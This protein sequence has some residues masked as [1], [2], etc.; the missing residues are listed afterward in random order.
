MKRLAPQKRPHYV[1]TERMSILEL[2]AARA[3]SAQQS[4]D[5]FLVTPATI[6]SW[7][8]RVDEQGPD[9]LL[10]IREPVNKFPDFVRYA[11]QRLKTMCPT[12]GKA[13]IAETLC[14]AGLHLG[15][16][17]VG[18]ILKEPPR[19][20]PPET[21]PPTV[22]RS[23][24]AWEHRRDRTLHTDHE[25]RGH[26]RDSESAASID[27]SRN[28]RSVLH[29]VQRTSPSHGARGPHAQ[30][31]VSSI[32]TRKPAAARRATQAMAAPLALRRA[33]NTDRRTARRSVHT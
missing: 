32:A 7:M 17:T 3:W 5:A 10:Q 13:K 29:L 24:P 19:P 11:V 4:A 14:R 25:R 31:S 18:R 9:P 21:N 12:L 20:L 6:A 22:W 27:I 15:T 26:A 28:A 30:R 23:R 16:T 1:P 33:A 2:R 8:K